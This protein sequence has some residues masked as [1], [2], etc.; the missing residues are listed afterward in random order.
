MPRRGRSNLS[1]FM[2]LTDVKGF[3]PTEVRIL[4]AAAF[5]QRR[6]AIQPV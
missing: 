1:A 2:R 6:S 3:D 5:A 4:A